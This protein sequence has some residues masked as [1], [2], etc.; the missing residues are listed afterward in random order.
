MTNAIKKYKTVPR[1]KEMISDGMFHYI[2]TLA[3][4]AYE[5]SLVRA[6]TDWIA[7]G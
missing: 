4:R 3:S 1:R 6:V 7:L 5:N 2:T